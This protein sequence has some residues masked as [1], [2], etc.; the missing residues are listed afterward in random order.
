MLLSEEREG[1]REGNG[2]G[3]IKGETERGEVKCRKDNNKKEKTE[4]EGVRGTSCRM[5]K[6]RSRMK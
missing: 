1:C 3:G 5:I 2:E 6:V 4:N